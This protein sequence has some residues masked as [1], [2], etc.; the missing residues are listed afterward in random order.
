M[1]AYASILTGSLLLFLLNNSKAYLYLKT[2]TDHRFVIKG[3][4]SGTARRKRCTGRDVG[5]GH[6]ASVLTAALS[7][8]LHVLTSPLSHLLTVYC[9]PSSVLGT[10]YKLSLDLSIRKLRTK[11]FKWRVLDSSS[12]FMPFRGPRV[13]SDDII[14]LLDFELHQKMIQKQYFTSKASAVSGCPLALGIMCVAE[15]SVF[16]FF[17]SDDELPQRRPLMGV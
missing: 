16:S 5:R 12:N 3:Y 14:I 9:L 6:G 8:D 2:K 15:G 11:E 1:F 4:T 7:Q 13:P 17:T 10:L